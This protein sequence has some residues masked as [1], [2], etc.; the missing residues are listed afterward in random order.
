MQQQSGRLAPLAMSEGVGDPSD[1]LGA[2]IDL[3]R[4]NGVLL[5]CDWPRG[6]CAEAA[7]RKRNQRAA[8]LPGDRDA[9]P[10]ATVEALM[11]SLRERGVKALTEPA[12]RRRLFELSD[13]QLAEVG[14]RLRGLKPHIAHAW[15]TDEVKVLIRTKDILNDGRKT[16]ERVDPRR[17]RREKDHSFSETP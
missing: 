11:F 10:Y 2:A 12:T 16:N 9:A 5:G 4:V 1:A 6:S 13:R 7:K 3:L 17:S 15:T 14:D 8:Q